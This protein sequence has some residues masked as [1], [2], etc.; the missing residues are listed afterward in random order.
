MSSHHVR[1]ISCTALALVAFAANSILC[2]IALRHGTIDA[3]TFSTIRLAAGAATLVLVNA[4]LRKE[5]SPAKGSWLSGGMLFLYAVPFS[6]AYTL[7]NTGTGALILFGCVQLT[8]MIAAIWSGERPPPL[9]WLGLSFAL[10]GLIYLVLPGLE[11]PSFA[12]AALMALAGFSWGVYSLRGRHATNPLAQTTNNFVRSVP[13]VFA[14]SLVSLPQFSVQR[15][16]VLLAVASGAL[17]SGLGYVAWYA[18]L[19]GLTA[20]RAA[21]VQLMVPILAALGGVVFLAEVVS[22]RLLLSTVLVL[23][24]IALALIGRESL[25]R[26]S[27]PSERARSPEKP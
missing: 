19:R 11:A 9:Q 16:G 18:A 17:A 8:M 14:V 3:A 26:K 24:G 5:P 15:Q 4:W 20:T 1:T 12:G 6:F 13:L 22:G 27:D 2:R 21:V 25:S 7:L 23:G 10:G